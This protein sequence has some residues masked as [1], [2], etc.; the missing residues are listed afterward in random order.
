MVNVHYYA[1]RENL[2][3]LGLFPESKPC[4]LPPVIRDGGN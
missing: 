3:Y 1:V 2:D 4:I